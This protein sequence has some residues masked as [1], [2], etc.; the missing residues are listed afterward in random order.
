MNPDLSQLINNSGYDIFFLVVDKFLNFNVDVGLKHFYPVYF[1][2]LNLKNSGQLLAHPQTQEYIKKI[3]DQNGHKVAILSFKPSAKIEHL[4]LQ[5]NWKCLNNPSRLN[6]L[7]EDKIKFFNICQK[8]NIPAVPSTIDIF[9]QMNFEKYQN[10]YG[11]KLVIQTHFGWAGNSTFSSHDWQETSDKIPTNAVVKYSPYITGTTLLN[12]C[13]LTHLGLLQSPPADQLTGL[14]Q[15][16]LNPFS[17]VGRQWP[18]TVSSKIAK[19]VH[20]ITLGFSKILEK[21]SYK[22]FFGLDFIVNEKENVFLLECNPRLTAS[23]AFYTQLELQNHLTPLFLFHLAEFL[24]SNYQFDL[25]AEQSRFNNKNITGS[26]VTPRLNPQ[27][28]ITEVIETH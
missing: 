28:R 6:R 14:T 9:N 20:D 23:F 10:M 4:C 22:G 11:N 21:S 5:N 25:T 7:F 19:Q 13:C 1:P 8:N 12:N 27:N 24:N 16:T 18:S 15:Y 2:N 3:S 26:Q 17:T